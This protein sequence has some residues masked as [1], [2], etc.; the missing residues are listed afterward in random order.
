MKPLAALA[1]F[2]AASIAMSQQTQ[3]TQQTPPQ[4]LQQ[5]PQQP[6]PGD[7]GLDALV[8]RLYAYAEQYRA[9]LPSLSCDERV[10]SQQVR[11]D[12]K[13]KWQVRVEGTMRD[14]RKTPPDPFDPFTE[15]HTFVKVNGKPVRAMAGGDANLPYFIQGFFANLIGFHHVELKDC[16]DFRVTPL[17]NGKGKAVPGQVQVEV[18][19]KAEPPAAACRTIIAGTHY[20]VIADPETGR[21]RHSERTIP[22]EAAVERN[23]AYFAS[24]DYAPQQFGD[25]TFWLPAKSSAH[26]P[27][28]TGR[29]EAAY[30]NCHRYTGE[31]RIVRDAGPD[32]APGAPQPQTGKPQ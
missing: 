31:M 7:P 21:I 19:R 23:E 3:Q 17:K 22:A 6:T 5:V 12:G 8:D 26:D 9:T 29:M 28:G 1:L 24:I 30:L 18:D 4:A 10:V 2:L 13:V 27:A 32:V 11:F 14:L 16:F 15:Q 25:R 20:M